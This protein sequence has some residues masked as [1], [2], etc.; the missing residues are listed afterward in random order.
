MSKAAAAYKTG[1]L[2]DREPFFAQD[3]PGLGDFGQLGKVV[4]I[5]LNDIFAAVAGRL[6]AGDYR[7]KVKGARIGQTAFAI[8]PVVDVNMDDICAHRIQHRVRVISAANRLLHIEHK[9]DVSVTEAVMK[10]AHEFGIARAGG[11]NILMSQ[12]SAFAFRG[13]HQHGQN[14]AVIVH[15]EEGRSCRVAVEYHI[16]R[17]E[18]CR[19]MEIFLIEFGRVGGSFF[20]GREEKHIFIAG[21]ERVQRGHMDARIAAAFVKPPQIR[22][23]QLGKAVDKNFDISESEADAAS[24]R[25]DCFLGIKAGARQPYA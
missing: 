6:K 13:L 12:R 1:S 21:G 14:L 25:V 16:F 15:S 18:I 4:M 2:S 10:L 7:V 22:L 5:D 11:G 24:D 19:G 23:L 9:A 20:V 17:A 3:P 8:P